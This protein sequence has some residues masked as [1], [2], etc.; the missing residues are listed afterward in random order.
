MTGAGTNGMIA[1]DTIQ[2]A[3]W[4]RHMNALHLRRERS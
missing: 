4:N 1:G 2:S 3:R